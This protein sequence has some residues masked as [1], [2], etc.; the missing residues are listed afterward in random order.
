MAPI[1]SLNV[2]L[3]SQVLQ[4]PEVIDGVMSAMTFARQ[5]EVQAWEQE[6]NP[7]EHTLCLEQ[8]AS[9]ALES[10]STLS[11]CYGLRKL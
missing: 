11:A 4:L 5:T 10:Q 1:P 9:K 6:I 3:L 7:C 8:G 2:C